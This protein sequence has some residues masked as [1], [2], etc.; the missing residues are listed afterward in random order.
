MSRPTIQANVALPQGAALVAEELA[1]VLEIHGHEA[2]QYNVLSP[3]P[4]QVIWNDD[5]SGFIGFLEERRCVLAWRSPVARFEDQAE[6]IAS[7]V[8]YGES[9]R[10]AVF[11]MEVNEASRTA[12]VALGMTPIWTGT[13]SYLELAT[14]SLR[15]GRRQKVR[16][17]KSHAVK[18]GLEWREA[19]PFSNQDDYEGIHR[20]EVRWKAERSERQTDSFLRT[21]FEELADFRRY[22]VAERSGAIIAFVTCTPVNK[23]GWYLQDIVRAPDAPRGA[24]EGAMAFALDT[25]QKEGYAFVSNGPLPFWRPDESWSDPHKFGFIGNQV[26]NFFNRQY[27]FR[28]INQFRSKFDPDRVEPLYVLRSRRLITLGVARSLTKLLNRHP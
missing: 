10:K 2:G 19:F 20:V 24:L 3:D 22:F 17:A 25:F 8:R 1:A 16:W 26:T 27:R 15:G 18:L 28:G 13:E 11:A 14:W 23:D 5:R 7:L 12:G 21:S 9:V 4:W 6:L